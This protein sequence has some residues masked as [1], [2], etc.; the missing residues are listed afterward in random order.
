MLLL[1][2]FLLK[3]F[4]TYIWPLA[5]R[6]SYVTLIW[7]AHTILFVLEIDIYLDI[8]YDSHCEVIECIMNYEH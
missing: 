1:T 5:T 7:V 2:S 8:G 4:Q 3:L 6:A